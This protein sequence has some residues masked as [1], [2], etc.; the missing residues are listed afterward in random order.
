MGDWRSSLARLAPRYQ[1][2]AES[3]IDRL[4][5]LQGPVFVDAA[6]TMMC[7][8]QWES[9]YPPEYAPAWVVVEWI[10]AECS[11]RDARVGWD[12]GTLLG[13]IHDRLDAVLDA[14]A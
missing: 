9:R 1:T 12:P 6:V 7:Q 3:D 10:R 8:A 5:R 4:G 13:R 14:A 2:V 11:L